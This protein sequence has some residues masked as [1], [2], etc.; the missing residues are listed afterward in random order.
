[1]LLKPEEV[2]KKPKKNKV[3]EVFKARAS[4]FLV[5]LR[6]PQVLAIFSLKTLLKPEEFS[7][8]TKIERPWL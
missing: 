2:S 4:Q 3:L 5:F 1:M 6:P 8:K 7:K